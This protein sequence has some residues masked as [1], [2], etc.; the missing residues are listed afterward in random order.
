MYH[1]EDEDEEPYYRRE[2]PEVIALRREN[3]ALQD[4]LKELRA[5]YSKALS[6]LISVPKVNEDAAVTS[7]RA[8]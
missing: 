6:D 3:Y 8:P 7:E 1:Y 5:K 2:D 4:E